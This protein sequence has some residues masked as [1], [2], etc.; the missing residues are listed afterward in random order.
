MKQIFCL[1]HPI[2]RQRAIEAVMNAPDGYY[3]TVQE[4]TRTSEQNRLLHAHLQELKGKPWA[5]KPRD[6]D[7]WKLLMVSGHAIV[8]GRPSDCVPGL[9]GEFVNLRES[10][11]KMGKSRLSSLVEYIQAWVSEHECEETH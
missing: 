4:P 6:M 11:A 9:E 5:G 2:A 1:A 7:E 8:T 3:V 10:T